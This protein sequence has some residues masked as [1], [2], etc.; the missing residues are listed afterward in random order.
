MEAIKISSQYGFKDCEGVGV[1]KKIL[2]F[3]SGC[4]VGTSYWN[5]LLFML[6]TCLGH[7]LIAGIKRWQPQGWRREGL[8][9]F[10]VCRGFSPRWAGSKQGSTAEEKQLRAHSKTKRD[11][12]KKQGDRPSQATPPG[13][14]SS[15]QASPP[16]V[17]LSVTLPLMSTTSHDR[18]TSL[19]PNYISKWTSWG[20]LHISHKRCP[21]GW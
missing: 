18:V 15:D 8:F 2:D 17:T 4:C 10:T 6:Y 21:D 13:P 1:H 5:L 16:S 20:H 3:T 19:N 7:F 9:W 14:T 11:Q 12:E